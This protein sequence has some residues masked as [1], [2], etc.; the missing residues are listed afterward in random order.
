VSESAWDPWARYLETTTD[1]RRPTR[2]DVTLIEAVMLW[3]DDEAKRAKAA[4]ASSVEYFAD[5]TA[6]FTRE[7]LEHLQQLTRCALPITE[8][9]EEVKK[10]RFV[11]GIITGNFLRDVIAANVLHLERHSMKDVADDCM[12]PFNLNRNL[13]KT[14]D[15]HLYEMSQATWNGH[16][17]PVFRPVAHFW[18]SSIR[19]TKIDGDVAF[20]CKTERFAE[21]L[22]D[23]EFFRLTGEKTK[24]SPRSP[25]V[26]R[27]GEAFALPATW[28]I[29]PSDIKVFT[30]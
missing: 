20:P 2:L 18:A 28:E 22:A 6:A 4:D 25:P 30:G 15:P 17:W 27:Q 11:R 19:R 14:G 8:I 3:P 5:K 13:N 26:L 12:R 16:I 7:G 9:H 29:A 24:T 23:A 10:G 21:F 1:P